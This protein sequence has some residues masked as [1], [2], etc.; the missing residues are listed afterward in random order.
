[1]HES[2]IIYVIQKSALQPLRKEYTQAV[3]REKQA[4]HSFGSL[5]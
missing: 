3:L 1:M 4:R 2:K 5:F